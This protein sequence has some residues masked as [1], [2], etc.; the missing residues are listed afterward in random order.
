VK[1]TACYCCVFHLNFSSFCVFGPPG[2]TGYADGLIISS[3]PGNDES[4]LYYFAIATD[5]VARIADGPAGGGGLLVV[6]DTL[7]VTDTAANTVV[8]L[9]LAHDSCEPTINATRVGFL[10][11]PL[12]DAPLFS[13]AFEQALYSVNSIFSDA[14]SPPETFLLHSVDTMNVTP[15]ILC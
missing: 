5:T 12:Y 8:V 1:Q 6:G 2:I 15:A 9:E 10:D 4:G 14:E 11:S 3:P 13:A 7:Y